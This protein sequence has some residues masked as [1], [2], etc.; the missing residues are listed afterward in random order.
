MDRNSIKKEKPVRVAVIG[1]KRI[2]SR[3][4]GLEKTVEEQ[5]SRLTARGYEFVLYN[6]GGHNVFGTKYDQPDR[7]RYRGMRVVT[8]PTL[9]GPAEVPLYSLLAVLHALI[10]GCSLFYFHASGPCVM[11]PLARLFGKRC[12]AMLHGIDSRRDK[13][14]GFAS[15]YLRQGEKAAVRLA[16]PCLVL[17]KN[18][19]EDLTKRYGRKP[20]L[21]HNGIRINE[22]VHDDSGILKRFG[23]VS[24]QYV[25]TVVRIVPEKGLHYLIPAFRRLKTDRKLLIAGGAEAK[26]AGYLKE[27]KELAG[28]DERIIFAGFLP[29]P[30]VDCLYR[31]CSVFVLASTLEG[32]ANAL[33]EAMA[34]GCCCLVSDIPENTE[35][36]EDTAFQFKCRDM[37]DLSKKLD[38]LLKDDALR[39]KL[40]AAARKRAGERY[41]WESCAERL[42]RVFQRT[43]ERHG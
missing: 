14:S 7:K 30:E 29:G 11:I 19:Q 25:L 22:E 21:I 41:S 36:T 24:G 39:E 2:P 1:H 34:A 16:D 15:W 13:W 35:V 38:T 18:M 40:G 3:E 33:L 37:K 12:V 5:T 28:D 31:N 10:T 43:E 17:S 8:V 27:L 42:D 9:P 20:E 4:G 6:R 32:M 23:V 26:C